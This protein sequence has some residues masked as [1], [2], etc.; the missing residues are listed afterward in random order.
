MKGELSMELLSTDVLVAGGGVGGLMSAYRAS[1]TGARVVL[2]LGSPG[3]SNR[4]SCFNTTLSESPEDEPDQFI[5]DINVSGAGIN[6]E[7]LVRSMT[8][9]IEAETRNLAA[10][11][12]LFETNEHGLSRRK[13]AGSSWPR[14]VFSEG[15]VGVDISRVLRRILS[16]N[17][18]VTI[19]KDAWI[20][21][22]T[23]TSQRVAGALVHSRRDDLWLQVSSKA[24]ILATGGAGRL[25]QNSSNPPGSYATGYSLALEAGVDLVDMEFISFEPFVVAAPEKVKGRDLPTTVLYEGARLR[26][27]LGA[28]IIV[29][30]QTPSKDLICR[31]MVREVR[32]GRGT[33]AGAVLYDLRQMLPATVQKYVQI[34]QALSPLG[35]AP[36]EAVLEVMPA[37]HYMM[38]GIRTNEHASTRLPG[39]Y[40]VGE[41]A[42]GVHGA[43]RLAG[44]GG[45]EVIAMGAIAGEAAGIF[46]LQH[47]LLDC[48]EDVPPRPELLP[49][50]RG[51]HDDW[52]LARLREALDSGCGILRDAEGLTK[53]VQ[54]IKTV[55]GELEADGRMQTFAGRAAILSLAIASAALARTESRGDHFRVDFPTRNDGDWLGNIALSLTADGSDVTIRYESLAGRAN[56]EP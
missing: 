22:L 20:L 8:E 15:M 40:A 32:E 3:A 55:R 6:N 25:F 34:Q 33:E 52:L 44:A 31:A 2:L 43:H 47:K 7:L 37:Q 41:V 5:Q 11:G 10:L 39:L 36:S 49:T 29:P 4:I 13:A 12:V 42:A 30:G 19:L 46:A 48:L 24:V 50:A 1:L 38:G 35:L 26:N 45:T 28:D 23:I 16:E 21:D 9:R 54:E 17:P 56:C 18:A 14:A 51:S 27:A 53:S